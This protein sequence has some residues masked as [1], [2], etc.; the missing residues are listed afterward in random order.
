MKTGKHKRTNRAVM[1]LAILAFSKF[2]DEGR[3][4]W[5]LGVVLGAKK[6]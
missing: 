4:M 3:T 5:L 2:G 6:M 1:K